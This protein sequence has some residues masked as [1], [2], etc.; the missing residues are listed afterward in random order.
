[1]QRPPRL[2]IWGLE[3]A[4]TTYQATIRNHSI[5]HARTI[6]IKGTL[7]QAKRAATAEFGQEQRDYDIVIAEVFDDGD[8]RIVAHR[9]VGDKV[10]INA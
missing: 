5:S 10:W 7:T 9:L 2:G 1:M 4:M 8:R 6:E 3:T